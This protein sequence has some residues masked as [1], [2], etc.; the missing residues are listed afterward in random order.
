MRTEPNNIFGLQ[1][2]PSH[3]EVDKVV[4]K[5]GNDNIIKRV[6]F[7]IK[8]SVINYSFPP[9][10]RLNIEQLAEQLRVSTTPVRECLN[11]LV[12]E[13]LIIVIPKMGF[14]MKEL[15]ESELRDLHELN[16]ILLGRSIICMSKD[17]ENNTT[18]KLPNM[19]S[20]IDRLMAPEKPSAGCLANFSADFFTYLANQSG[21]IQVI[22]RVRNINDRLHYIRRCEF[23]LRGD[24]AAQL[25]SLLQLCEDSRYEKLGQALEIYHADRMSF[26][27]SVIKAQ[28]F[29]SHTEAESFEA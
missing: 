23:G 7:G 18:I 25:L 9:A 24:S 20:M 14:F 29:S 22:Q 27:P 17:G 4:L 19:A 11:R 12:A 15:M 2:R 8:E 5:S 10:E 1:S 16:Q 6:Y 21:N 13:E 28:K 26:L 3:I